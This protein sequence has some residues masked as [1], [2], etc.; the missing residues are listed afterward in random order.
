LSC[1]EGTRDQTLIW[2]LDGVEREVFEM[3]R[4]LSSL[5]K[6]AG[7]LSIEWGP[8]PPPPQPPKAKG[9]LFGF[10]KK[11]TVQDVPLVPLGPTLPTV[12]SQG[13]LNVQIGTLDQFVTGT[14]YDTLQQSGA[15]DAIARDG[16]RDGAVVFPLRREL[17][18]GLANLPEARV[19]EVARQ[20]GEDE[21]I[22]ATDGEE[23]AAL[24]DLVSDLTRLA[25]SA[26]AAGT[27]TWVPRPDRH[28]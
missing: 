19:A 26:V 11:Q 28:G 22:G 17:R 3:E 15:I 9:G 12:Q 1:P 5:L 21:E 27:S 16:G 4:G 6:A 18:D 2:E 24:R 7:V 10:G 20:W 8:M 25:Q 14:P 23:F 13:I